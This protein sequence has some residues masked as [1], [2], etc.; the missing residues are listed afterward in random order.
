MKYFCCW[1]FLGLSLFFFA[2]YFRGAIVFVITNFSDDFF[3]IIIF[4][5]DVIIATRIGITAN[6]FSGIKEILEGHEQVLV[7]DTVTDHFNAA[8]ID[9]LADVHGDAALGVEHDVVPLDL[10][11]DI[12]MIGFAP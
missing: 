2:N 3:V 7:L 10:D 1:N 9:V 5:N 11:G 4:S 6:D 8:G 12:A